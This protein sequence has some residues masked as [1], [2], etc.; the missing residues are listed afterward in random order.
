MS[1]FL[2]C[3][4]AKMLWQEHDNK[5]RILAQ[6]EMWILIHYHFKNIYKHY[7]YCIFC[8]VKL[9]ERYD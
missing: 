8:V 9:D 6:Y 7:E 1:H 4:I 3:K 5:E 2:G